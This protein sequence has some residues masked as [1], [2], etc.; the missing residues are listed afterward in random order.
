VARVER[1]EDLSRPLEHLRSE[2]E[3]IARGY[4]DLLDEGEAA[5]FDELLAL[6]RRVFPSSSTRSASS[7]R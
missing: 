4:R 7:A 2:S 1:H 5:Q 3:R 6:S